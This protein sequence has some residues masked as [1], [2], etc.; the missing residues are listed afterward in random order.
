MNDKKIGNK[1]KYKLDDPHRKVITLQGN[2]IT[3]G[4]LRDNITLYSTVLNSYPPET[5]SR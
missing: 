2:A 3:A 5:N 1:H 4:P